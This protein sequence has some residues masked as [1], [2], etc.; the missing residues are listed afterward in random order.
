[1]CERRVMEHPTHFAKYLADC[2]PAAPSRRALAGR[3]GISRSHLSEIVTGAKRPSLEL[4]TR[5]E[6]LT[7]GAVPVN[8]WIPAEGGAEACNGEAAA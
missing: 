6:R 8:Q 3:L 5:I 2:G 7:D 4:A 1:M